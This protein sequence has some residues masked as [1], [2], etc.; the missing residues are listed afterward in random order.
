MGKVLPGHSIASIMGWACYGAMNPDL[1]FPF[2]FG[3]VSA[4]IG[5][6]A[7]GRARWACAI[8]AGNANGDMATG[9]ESCHL[10]LPGLDQT[11]LAPR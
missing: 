2:L 10:M 1:V 3:A 9:Q 4:I 6:T 8:S 5:H 7:D 11:W